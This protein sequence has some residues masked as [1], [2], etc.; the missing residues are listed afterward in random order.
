MTTSLSSIH[1]WWCQ[2]PHDKDKQGIMHKLRKNDFIIFRNVLEPQINVLQ[3]CLKYKTEN[4]RE[5]DSNE[6]KTKEPGA[7]LKNFPVVS[8]LCLSDLADHSCVF[9][10]S[11]RLFSPTFPSRFRSVASTW[12]IV[13]CP[14]VT[15][16][17]PL[18]TSSSP[19]TIR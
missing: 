4:K 18:P 2:S 10:V 16:A 14:V 6:M 12:S 15:A 3:Q 1:T 5:K 9:V 17:A 7:Y 11:R 8:F 19:A 13:R